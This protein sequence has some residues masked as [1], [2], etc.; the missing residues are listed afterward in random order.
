MAGISGI[1]ESAAWQ[2]LAR[3]PHRAYFSAGVTATLLMAVW[4]SV[5]LPTAG[6][7]AL[8]A[9]LVH[10][11]MM[12]LGVF[13]PFMLGFVFTAG[14]RWLGVVAPQRHLPLA[15]GQVLGLVATLLGFAA[16]GRWPALG[17]FMLF[18]VW[19]WATWL[20]IRCIELSSQ[21]DRRHAYCILGAMIV[22]NVALLACIGWVLSGDAAFWPVARGLI[23]WGWIV[24]IFLVVAHRMIPFFTQSI[25]PQRSIWRPFWALYVWLGGC[26]VFFLSGQADWLW[27]HG[28]TAMLLSVTTGYAAWTWAGRG[29]RGAAG[30]NRLLAMLHLSFAWLPLAFLLYALD[31]LGLATGT[32]ATHAVALGFCTTMMVGFVT[33]VTL[34]HSGRAL[35]ASDVHWNLY[36]GLHGVAAFRVL[37]ALFGTVL[38]NTLMPFAA[39]L[40]LGL[41]VTWAAN[42]LPV[43]WRP[44]ADGMEG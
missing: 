21:P 23:L 35:Q 12:P 17:L 13:P 19:W 22:G 11:L 18:A 6:V 41:I 5:A 30:G 29:L 1:L 24:P 44:R 42:V 26:A 33:R 37:L 15:I 34:G 28:L 9:P 4:W 7:T 2:R 25:V 39:M 32:A 16:G 27:L 14:P 3:V 43:Y 8:P 36:L 20:W 31:D 38:P 40:W 10:A